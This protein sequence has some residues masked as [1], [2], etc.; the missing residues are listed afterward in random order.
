[1]ATKKVKYTKTGIEKLPDNKP[2]RYDI[3]TDSGKTNYSGTAQRGRVKERIQ[4]H[5]GDIPGKKVKI[6]QFNSIK[7]AQNSEDRV[8]KRRQPR[9]NKKGK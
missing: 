7:D 6:T 2:V 9:F 5:L 4:E 8:I 3:E 1:M